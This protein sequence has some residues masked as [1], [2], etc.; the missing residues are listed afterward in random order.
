MRENF[1][2]NSHRTHS[3]VHCTILHRV[4]PVVQRPWTRLFQFAHR[5]MGDRLVRSL[6]RSRTR[7]TGN[8]DAPAISDGRHSTISR[9]VWLLRDEV[10]TTSSLVGGAAPLQPP[11]SGHTH[12]GVGATLVPSPGYATT[13]HAACLLRTRGD[14]FP[15]RLSPQAVSLSHPQDIPRQLTHAQS[16]LSPTKRDA[17]CALHDDR[18][19]GL[20]LSVDHCK[21]GAIFPKPARISLIFSRILRR[22]RLSV[23]RSLST[24]G[25]ESVESPHLADREVGKEKKAITPNN[26]FHIS[27]LYYLLVCSTTLHR[28]AEVYERSE[29]CP[30]EQNDQ[31]CAYTW[32]LQ[33]YRDQGRCGRWSVPFRHS[34]KPPLPSAPP[35]TLHLLL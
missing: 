31:S 3:K 33:Y 20:K 27:A 24:L 14:A 30:I 23:R 21:M 18:L 5:A 12:G 28:R 17:F 4:E 19:R 7:Q 6:G 22:S 2:L 13:P 32:Q 15:Q 8:E 26:D 10:G 16:C 25:S 9:R 29:G 34:P 11:P 1:P 35:S